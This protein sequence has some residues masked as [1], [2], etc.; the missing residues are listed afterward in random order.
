MNTWTA[1]ANHC[2]GSPTPPPVAS[3]LAVTGRDVSRRS[4]PASSI[5]TDPRKREA[6]APAVRPG[7][8]LTSPAY[9]ADACASMH[10]PVPQRNVTAA[11]GHDRVPGARVCA[12][13]ALELVAQRPKPSAQ[14]LTPRPKEPVEVDHPIDRA[15][16]VRHG[17]G[18]TPT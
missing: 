2:C 14:R 7:P 15:D 3:G 9:G 6:R 12:E 11:G 18:V 4:W 8:A 1:P 10:I 5:S 13:V 17:I 16:D